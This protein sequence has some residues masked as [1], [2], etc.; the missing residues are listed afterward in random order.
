MSTPLKQ[1]E[2]AGIP[3]PQVLDVEN[4]QLKNKFYI[5]FHNLDSTTGQA[6]LDEVPKTKVWP[7]F[8]GEEEYDHIEF[9]RGI[10]MIKEDFEFPYRLVAARLNTL[11]SILDHRWYIKLRQAHGNQS[12]T[13][14]QTKIIN[15]WSNDS[16]RFE[17]ETAFESAKFNADKE[18]ALPWFFQQK[19]RLYPE[20]SEFMI[21]RKILT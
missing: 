7:H 12:W 8:S 4:S 18:K 9:I 6:L 19:D 3:N 11:Y 17:V 1:D 21:Q 20:M 10:D 14:W 2:G 16:W 13:W 15:K 5:H